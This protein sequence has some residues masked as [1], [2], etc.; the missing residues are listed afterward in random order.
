[1]SKSLAGTIVDEIVEIGRSKTE[2]VTI[3]YVGADNLYTGPTFKNGTTSTRPYRVATAPGR[4]VSF[5]HVP[6]YV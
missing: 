4:F 2:R 1:M 6:N 5:P 3:Y